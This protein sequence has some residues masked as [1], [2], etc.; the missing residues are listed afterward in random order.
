MNLS[1]KTKGFLMMVFSVLGIVLY[2]TLF[3]NILDAFAALAIVSGIANY[4]AFNTIIKI[5]PAILLLAGL[6]GAGLLYY[7]GYKTATG[8]GINSMLLMVMGALEIIL[9]VTLFATI[10]AGFET[11]RTHD[12][13][14]YFTALSTVVTIMPT[15][16]FLAGIL[17]GGVTAVGGYRGR[18]R[19]RAIA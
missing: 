19:A 13:I 16:L 15:V 12:N 7:A 8:A 18:K 4:V 3:D 2:V 10:L 11:L 1:G 17:G 14:T 9:F 5:A 6:F